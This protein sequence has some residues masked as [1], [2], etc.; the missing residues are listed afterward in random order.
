MIVDTR[1]REVCVV[2]GSYPLELDLQAWMC[3]YEPKVD[4]PK[5]II[6]NPLEYGKGGYMHHVNCNFGSVLLLPLAG[7]LVD[8]DKE[9]RMM[10]RRFVIDDSIQAN[11]T[12]HFKHQ[13][14]CWQKINNNTIVEGSM[15]ICFDYPRL[16]RI[17]LPMVSEPQRALTEVASTICCLSQISPTYQA[18]SVSFRPLK[19]VSGRTGQFCES[20][21]QVH[22]QNEDKAGHMA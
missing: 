11:R 10:R 12:I 13:I 20:K 21:S 14:I 18:E 22:S 1:G 4:F 19:Q 3:F 9:G 15:V 7:F 2:G 8:V 6:E 17:N 5:P 16:S